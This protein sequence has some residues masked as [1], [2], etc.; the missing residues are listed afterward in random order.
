MADEVLRALE[1][2]VRFPAPRHTNDL[3][4]TVTFVHQ[5]SAWGAIQVRRMWMEREE[6]PVLKG[7]GIY[8]G[9]NGQKFPRGEHFPRGGRSS[10]STYRMGDWLRVLSHDAIGICAGVLLTQQKGQNVLQV[11]VL[12]SKHFPFAGGQSDYLFVQSRVIY[13]CVNWRSV[14]T[15]SASRVVL[16]KSSQWLSNVQQLSGFRL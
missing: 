13:L 2:Y 4:S 3:N 6:A 7:I 10:L 12:P 1:E 9:G 11:I 8:T 15:S 14:E 5:D 16:S